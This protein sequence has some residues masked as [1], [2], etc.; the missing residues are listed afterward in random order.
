MSASPELAAPRV[1]DLRAA[2]ARRLAGE[3]FKYLLASALA[4]ALD[5]AV[6][7]GLTELAGLHYLIAAACGFTAGLVL[8]YVLSV[9]FIF[10]ERRLRSRGLQF[11]VFAGIGLLGLALTE[12]LMALV[13]G[14]FGVNYALAKLLVAGA[15]F[16]F[17]FAARRVILFTRG[18][19]SP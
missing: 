15:S 17:N 13:V 9:A 10:Q 3:S 1:A 18:R 6:L 12:I 14:R 11:A 16:T 7:V 4:F 8:T 19:R 5:F 2:I